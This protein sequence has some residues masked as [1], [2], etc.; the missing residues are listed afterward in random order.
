MRNYSVGSEELPLKKFCWNWKLFKKI[1]VGSES[2]LNQF[3][4][5][6]DG[7]KLFLWEKKYLF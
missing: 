2:Y 4:V 3:P 7:F 6:S 1:S 5:G